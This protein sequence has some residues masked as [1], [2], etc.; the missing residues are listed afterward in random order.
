MQS[1]RKSIALRIE[2]KSNWALFR[3]VYSACPCPCPTFLGVVFAENK[4]AFQTGRAPP[5]LC[6]CSNS[7]TSWTFSFWLVPVCL[8]PV[9]EQSGK[10]RDGGSDEKVVDQQPGRQGVDSKLH[11][12]AGLRYFYIYHVLVN[13]DDIDEM[14]KVVRER[15]RTYEM[16]LIADLNF[17]SDH[18]QTASAG[19]GAAGVDLQGHQEGGPWAEHTECTVL[20]TLGVVEWHKHCSW[21]QRWPWNKVDKDMSGPPPLQLD[22]KARHFMCRLLKSSFRKRKQMLRNWDEIYL[23]AIITPL[24]DSPPQPLESMTKLIIVHIITGCPFLVRFGICQ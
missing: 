6:L 19:D 8:L 11:P 17:V 4:R 14:S 13:L 18:E 3:Y 5:P 12:R 9:G 15:K 24:S 2:I 16:T 1:S 10:G 7:C 23:C 20:K 21:A 22:Y